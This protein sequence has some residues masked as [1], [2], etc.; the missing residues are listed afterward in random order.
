MTN[1]KLRFLALPPSIF[2]SLF[3]DV[4]CLLLTL[5][6][7]HTSSVHPK[8]VCRGGVTTDA[9]GW[10]KCGADG[11]LLVPGGLAC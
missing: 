8:P 5:R 11:T 4:H 10:L 7:V 9:M 2:G 6:V 3:G 1:V